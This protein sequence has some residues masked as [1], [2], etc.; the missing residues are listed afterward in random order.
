[1]QFPTQQKLMVHLAGVEGLKRKKT[2]LQAVSCPSELI[3]NREP[4]N[5]GCS[6]Q[7]PAVKLEGDEKTFG[8]PTVGLWRRRISTAASHSS[9]LQSD[10]F[11][12]WM[13]VGPA[14]AREHLRSSVRAQ[15][16]HSRYEAWPPLDN[17][18]SWR[19]WEQRQ[20]STDV[21]RRL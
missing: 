8:E 2:E 21:L 16:K 18:C 20:V 13:A 4:Q 9:R 5:G 14:E 12:C 6:S 17:S 19:S 10:W 11:F 1:M 7:V 3:W 15:L